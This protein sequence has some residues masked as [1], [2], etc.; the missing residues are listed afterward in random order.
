MGYSYKNMIENAQRDGFANEKTMWK[1]V[2]GMEK[3]LCLIEKEHPE[4]YWRFMRE[5]HGI[6]YNSHYDEEFAM[7]DVKNLRYTDKNGTK[8]TGAHWT[9]E[10]IEQA[11]KGYSFPNG[12]NKWDKF[13]A[14]NVFY[15]DTCKVLS[16]D[17]IIDS[18]YQFFFADEDA[19]SCKIWKYMAA[20]RECCDEG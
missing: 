5:Q 12:T 4:K 15:A 19:P 9:C 1:S 14:F 18:A 20:M 2:E 17:H 11:T 13:V 6:M 16:E 3:L 7:Y 8:H 10:Q